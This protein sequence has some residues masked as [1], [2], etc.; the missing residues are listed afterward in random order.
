MKKNLFLEFIGCLE[1]LAFKPE[2]SLGRRYSEDPDSLYFFLDP[3]LLDREKIRLSKSYRKLADKRQVFPPGIHSNVRNRLIHTN[4]V[5][6]LSVILSEILGLNTH[7]AEAIAHGH[8]IGHTPFGHLGERLIRELSKSN[9]SHNVMSVV[10]AQKI[11]RRGLG[12]NLTYETLEGIL[13]HSRGNNKMS[14]NSDISAEATLVM[15]CDKIAYTFSD[16]NDALKVKFLSKDSLPKLVKYFG[17]N[18]RERIANV[19]YNVVLE[20]AEERK[21]SFSKS[22]CAQHFEEL[23]SWMYENVYFKLDSQGEREK[24]FKNLESV[25]NFITKRFE[26]KLDPGLAI[27]TMTDSEALSLSASICNGKAF[28][29]NYGFSETIMDFVGKKIEITDPD[30]QKADFSRDNL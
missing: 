10:T 1:N 20:S 29:L 18:Q 21:V 9:F 27:S 4:E 25:Y 5:V 11:E 22:E 26:G 14:V 8:D 13:H 2:N 7:L 30:L 6:N 3:F 24:V 28:D 17:K 12:L 23:K 15:Y 16:L 19:I